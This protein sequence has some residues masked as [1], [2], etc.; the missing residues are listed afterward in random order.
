MEPRSRG[1]RWSA[2]LLLLVVLG[3]G[4]IVEVRSALQQRR[5]TDL[6]VYLRAAWAVRVGA[7]LYSVTDSNG[8]HYHYPPPLAILLVPLADPPDGTPGYVPFA[9]SVA[10]WYLLSVA[11]LAAGV[12]VLAQALEGPG[13]SARSWRWWAL[14]LVPVWACIVDVGWT[15]ARGQVNLFLVGLVCALTAALIRGQN[16]RAGAWLAAAISLK[17]IPAFLLVVPV[18]R[19]DGRM[20]VGVGAGLL[21]LLVGL[22][23]LT[24]GPER[25]AAVYAQWAGSVLGPALG[26]QASERDDELLAI[27]ATDNASFQAV[28]H[29]WRHLDPATRPLRSEP[30]TKTAH[31]LIGGGLTLLVLVVRANTPA[32]RTLQMGLL[33][34]LMCLLS[35]VCH[36]HYFALGVPLCLGVLATRWEQ[37]GAAQPLPGLMLIFVVTASVQLLT[38]LPGAWATE[39]RLLGVPT[40]AF[41]AVW[42]TGLVVLWRTANKSAS[43]RAA[44]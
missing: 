11:A 35:P 14:R 32:R 27:N 39:A 17:V 12:Q 25:T 20:L 13:V 16:E 10:L 24:W 9:V 7:D 33:A 30:F 31:L 19:R 28:L 23:W 15:L 42:A 38:R 8:W 2:G 37:L 26:G 4:V 21:V 34:S 41:L 29:N 6:E 1:Q 22:P 3:F 18:L 5:K 40:A 36:L 43:S 44:A